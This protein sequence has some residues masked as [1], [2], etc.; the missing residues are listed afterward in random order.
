[1]PRSNN[2]PGLTVSRTVGNIIT[3]MVGRT[4]TNQLDRAVGAHGQDIA[5]VAAE[6]ARRGWAEGN[7]GNISVRLGAWPA[8]S[9][10]LVKR[11]NVRMRDLA[12]NPADGLCVLR[13]GAGDRSYSVI[14]KGARPSSELPTHVA[15]HDALARLRHDDRVVVHTHP[16]ALITLTHR[17]SNAKQ[18]IARLLGAHTEA[19]LMLQDRLAAIRFLPPGSMA[20]GRA[21][22]E[23]IEH[24]SA[25]IWP[26]HGIVAV[27]PTAAAA[28]DLIELTE[29]AAQIV[30]NLG[31]HAGLSPAQQKTIRKSFGLE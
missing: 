25:V 15:V 27:G 24:C 10:L 30:L 4:T 23:V 20:L 5:T 26:M 6:L 11:A 2:R 16:T 12:R 21:T 1:M 8:V 7:A 28:L 9:S 31:S 29:K 13:F 3:S 19:P 17:F 22:A 14:P 18:L